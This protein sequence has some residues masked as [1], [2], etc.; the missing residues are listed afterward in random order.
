MRRRFSWVV[1]RYPSKPTC[2]GSPELSRWGTRAERASVPPTHEYADRSGFGSAS[3]S[4]KLTRQDVEIVARRIGYTQVNRRRCRDR[5]N[6][7]EHE[8]L[9]TVMDHTKIE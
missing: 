9:K 1:L 5:E 7:C 3:G 4:F 8:K 6:H 2:P